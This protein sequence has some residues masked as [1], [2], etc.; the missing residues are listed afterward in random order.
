MD[1]EY[2][3]VE[4]NDIWEVKKRC[5]FSS[6]YLMGRCL[7]GLCIMTVLLVITWWY[8]RPYIHLMLRQKSVISVTLGLHA[9]CSPT[10]GLAHV[11]SKSRAGDFPSIQWLSLCLPKAAYLNLFI[12]CSTVLVSSLW[13]VIFLLSVAAVDSDSRSSLS[14]TFHSYFSSSIRKKNPASSLAMLNSGQIFS[15]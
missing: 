1:T 3:T 12:V 2:P 13:E 14:P 4:K 7:R 6:E 10:G 8:D 15:R 9:V 5:P 11:V